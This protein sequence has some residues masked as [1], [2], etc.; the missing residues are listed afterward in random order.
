MNYNYKIIDVTDKDGNT[1]TD[2]ISQMK[3]NHPCMSGYILYPELLEPGAFLLLVWNDC[4]EKMLRT[5]R[6][7]KITCGFNK[8]KVTTRNS[9]YVLEKIG[10]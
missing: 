9:I 10:D 7:E 2:F 5:S 3:Q 1:K 8:M 6:V 4:S